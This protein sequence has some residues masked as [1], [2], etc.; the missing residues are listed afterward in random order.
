MRN[1]LYPDCN[2]QL[3]LTTM[4]ASTVV[5]QTG[6]RGSSRPVTHLGV[7]RVNEALPSAST[8]AS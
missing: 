3:A 1:P 5:Q 8:D 7:L 2:L 4:T 6:S